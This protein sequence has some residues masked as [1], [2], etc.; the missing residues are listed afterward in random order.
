MTFRM[1]GFKKKLRLL[2]DAPGYEEVNPVYDKATLRMTDWDL[3]LKAR[4]GQAVVDKFFELG[5]IDEPT[6]EKKNEAIERAMKG[7]FKEMGKNPDK[8][9][10]KY[11]PD[12]R[13]EHYM[14]FAGQVENIYLTGKGGGMISK[15][16]V[17]EY[18]GYSAAVMRYLSPEARTLFS[19]WSSGGD[20]LCKEIYLAGEE[21]GEEARARLAGYYKVFHGVASAIDDFVERRPRAVYRGVSMDEGWLDQTKRM[22]L[23]VAIRGW[24]PG[25]GTV[26]GFGLPQSFS[27]DPGEALAFMRRSH[28]DTYT[29]VIFKLAT[30][31]SAPMASVSSVPWEAEHLMRPGEKYRISHVR[32]NFRRPA[33][34]G[35]PNYVVTLVQAGPGEKADYVFSP[36]RDTM[37]ETRSE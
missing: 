29:D 20:G 2:P 36:R 25:D 27:E 15:E 33:E 37:A 7:L 17:T 26:F 34:A 31:R 24:R 6:E 19:I 12:E 23:L 35:M 9:Y 4:V 28:R 21:A 11:T 3:E 32:K 30:D 10:G 13:W 22:P 8:K 14:K 16:G 1:E 18:E 5:L